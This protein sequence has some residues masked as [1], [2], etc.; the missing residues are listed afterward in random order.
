MPRVQLRELHGV[1]RNVKLA[2]YVVFLRVFSERSWPN[3]RHS[4][5]GTEES[6]QTHQSR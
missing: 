2:M 4:Y 1:Q 3:S 6:Y 5:R